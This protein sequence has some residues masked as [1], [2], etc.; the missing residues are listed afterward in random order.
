MAQFKRAALHNYYLA[1]DN[2]FSVPFLRRISE[3]TNLTWANEKA[4]INVIAVGYLILLQK[5]TCEIERELCGI[6]TWQ[7][8]TSSRFRRS[9]GR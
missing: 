3:I 6:V 9:C 7:P 4:L 5:G 1:T 2:Q 8:E